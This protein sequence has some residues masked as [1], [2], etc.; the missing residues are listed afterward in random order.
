MWREPESS[1]EVVRLV[2]LARLLLAGGTNLQKRL[3]KRSEG[4]EEQVEVWLRGALRDARN[5]LNK[6]ID[7]MDTLADA[8]SA[9]RS[10]SKAAPG[11]GELGQIDWVRLIEPFGGAEDQLI[12]E[13]IQRLRGA[14]GTIPSASEVRADLE[15][16]RSQVE[17]LIH[18]QP[19][20]LPV[21]IAARVLIGLI[22]L[23]TVVVVGMLATAASAASAGTEIARVLLPAAVGLVVTGLCG[24][25][26]KAAQAAAERSIPS[27]GLKTEYDTLNFMLQ[28]LAV[29]LPAPAEISPGSERML[30]RDI[31]L[32]AMLN[33]LHIQELI[34]SR[35]WDADSKYV[36]ELQQLRKTLANA[37]Q[38]TESKN[39]DDAAY[40]SL[41]GDLCNAEN[42]F[43]F[44][45]RTGLAQAMTSGENRS[46]PRNRGSGPTVEASGH[47]RSR[48]SEPVRPP[49]EPPIGPP[50]WRSPNPLPRNPRLPQSPSTRRRP[51]GPSS[52]GGG[53]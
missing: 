44:R 20:S 3:Q 18:T 43:A 51:R 33:S 53:R 12:Q 46:A 15:T 22:S 38:A 23:A 35:G 10:D 42:V 28:G 4:E 2:E 14:D 19:G 30:A 21:D 52:P 11:L 8:V 7:G 6:T 49:A 32:V 47:G 45:A 39:P 26:G 37:A 40:S 48:P 34:E 17:L 13:A 50:P 16:L 41:K 24:H 5:L 31:C 25:L 36:K 9:D 1:P 27:P 29:N